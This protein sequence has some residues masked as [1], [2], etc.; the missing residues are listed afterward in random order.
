M[1]NN[2]EVY[3]GIENSLQIRR[4]VLTSSINFIR[5]LERYEHLKEMRTNKENEVLYLKTLLKE[6]RNSLNVY[7]N[8]I[9]Y[10]E[11]LEEK[12]TKTRYRE[13]K[14]IKGE[15]KQFKLKLKK[16]VEK[17][18]PLTEMDRLKSELSEIESKLSGLSGY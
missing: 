10:V 1:Q 16:V 11:D 7:S 5:L 13:E 2:K 12:P 6:I 8:H 15:K 18:R 3:V 17:K 14:E 9:P 4:E